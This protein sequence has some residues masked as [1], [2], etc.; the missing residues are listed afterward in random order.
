MVVSHQGP[1]C[2]GDPWGLQGNKVGGSGILDSQVDQNLTSQDDVH[3][4]Y[5]RSKGTTAFI[6]PL[7][8]SPLPKS[9]KPAL[10]PT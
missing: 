6:P 3:L 4:N 2:Q 10:H 1:S 5:Y 8:R 7:L 9:Q